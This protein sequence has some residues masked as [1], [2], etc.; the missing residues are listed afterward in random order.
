MKSIYPNIGAFISKNPLGYSR[1]QVQKHVSVCQEYTFEESVFVSLTVIWFTC[2]SMIT[3][4][5]SDETKNKVI[6]RSTNN[7]LQTLTGI[8]S[9]AP[10]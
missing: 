10:D 8:Q 1:V 5:F 3:K 9:M 2:Q 6:S 4:I 7:W